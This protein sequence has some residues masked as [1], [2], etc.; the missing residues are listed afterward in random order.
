MGTIYGWPT[1]HPI[2]KQDM[3]T[4]TNVAITGLVVALAFAACVACAVFF[5][6]SSWTLRRERMRR[7]RV[8]VAAVFLDNYNRI[9]VN[10]TDGMLP[11][12]DIASLAGSEET[13]GSK[14]S[15]L[16]SSGASGSTDTTVL[17]MDLTP[18]HEAFVSAMRMSWAWKSGQT[19]TPAVLTN[20]AVKSQVNMNS[21][22]SDIRRG[23]YGTVTSSVAGSRPVRLS[24][25]KFLEMFGNAAS[26]LAVR[27]TGQSEGISRLGV[28]Y[29]QILTT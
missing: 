15:A 7:R 1:D 4:G 27:V 13:P 11:M 3:L 18:G 5:A 14:R 25:A 17:G 10:S 23:S 2:S 12:C 21:A 19:P 9:L 29:D 24:I 6:V 22:M 26:Q 28:L 20:E 8:V 16:R